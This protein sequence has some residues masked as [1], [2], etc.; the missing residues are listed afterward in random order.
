MSLNDTSFD[1]RI[2]RGLDS[3]GGPPPG[4]RTGTAPTDADGRRS[5]AAIRTENRLLRARAAALERKL[6]DSRE[7]H[8]R[9]IDR[10]EALLSE[11]RDGGTASDRRASDSTAS[12]SAQPSRGSVLLA[13]VRARLSRR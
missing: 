2:D 7:E 4:E 3:T 13:A 12:D 6:A 5:R 8:R 11:R 10:Y 1:G 9:V